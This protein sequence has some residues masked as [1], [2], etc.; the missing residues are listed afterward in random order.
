MIW[1]KD[2]DELADYCSQE[3][4]YLL[5]KSGRFTETELIEARY[6]LDLKIALLNKLQR[7][8]ALENPKAEPEKEGYTW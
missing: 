6:E 2:I 8:Y 3:E 4:D 1:T 5:R 7:Y